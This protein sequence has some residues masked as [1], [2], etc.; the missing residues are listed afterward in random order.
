M[1]FCTN[2]RRPPKRVNTNFHFFFFLGGLSIWGFL[3][4][5]VTT[6][7]NSLGGTGL[8]FFSMISPYLFGQEHN[9]SPC[10]GTISPRYSTA[11]LAHHCK[12]WV[13][14]QTTTSTASFYLALL[15]G[16]YNTYTMDF[17]DGTFYNIWL[18]KI[19]GFFA[20]LKKKLWFLFGSGMKPMMKF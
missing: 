15:K 19:E 5:R 7:I 6:C 20:P 13:I 18:W 4:R 2:F 1:H 12:I 11:Q 14:W 9:F 3:F 16:Q 10:H 17:S 8:A